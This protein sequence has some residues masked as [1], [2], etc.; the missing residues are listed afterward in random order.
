MTYLNQDN[1]YQTRFAHQIGTPPVSYSQW[2]PAGAVIGYVGN[3]GMSFGCHVHY[4][5]LSG[6][7][8][9]D[10]TPFI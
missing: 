2:V 9:V 3:T 10:P 8:F 4:E 6:A 5:V 1:G 7:A